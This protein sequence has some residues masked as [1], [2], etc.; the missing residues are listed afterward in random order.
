MD[1]ISLTNYFALVGTP[2][3]ESM[4]TQHRGMQFQSFGKPSIFS[5]AR[6][7][8]STCSFETMLNETLGE[9]G[10][11]IVPITA[12]NPEGYATTLTPHSMLA[13]CTL[14]WSCSSAD[15]K[16][17]YSWDKSSFEIEIGVVGSQSLNFLIWNCPCN[18]AQ[19]SS[20]DTVM[21]HRYQRSKSGLNHRIIT[22]DVDR[23]ETIFDPFSIGL[24]E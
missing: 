6:S 22:F 19:T 20:C 8:S 5:I 9:R 18:E 14:R 23:L 16:V 3:V 7:K 2:G 4:P 21:I 17:G 11:S 24:K 1:G 13:T 10:M 12:S 15:L